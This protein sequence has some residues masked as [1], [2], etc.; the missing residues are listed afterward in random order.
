MFGH[1]HICIIIIKGQKL[2]KYVAGKI[3]PPDAKDA[4]YEEWELAVGKTNSWIANSVTSIGNQLGKFKYPRDAW[5][6]VAW[7]YTVQFNQ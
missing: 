2:W 3:D 5:N 4:N 6:Y 1:F 7:L